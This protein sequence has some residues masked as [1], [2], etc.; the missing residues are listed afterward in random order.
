[1]TVSYAMSMQ[2]TGMGKPA[3]DSQ[4]GRGMLGHGLGDTGRRD[5]EEWGRQQ[6]QEQT[7]QAEG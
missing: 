2:T 4:E 1:M 5:E 3:R 6:H 7:E